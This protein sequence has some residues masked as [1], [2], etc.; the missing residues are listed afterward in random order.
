M[1]KIVIQQH[2][3]WRTLVWAIGLA[4]GVAVLCAG[5]F[6]QRQIELQSDITKMRSD[7]VRQKALVKR[8]DAELERLSQAVAGHERSRQ[9]ERQAYAEV[10]RHLGEVQSRILGLEEE[11]AFYR[12]IVAS[13]DQ[14]G[15][16]VRKLFLFP[17]AAANKFRYQVVLTR[18]MKDD[19]VMSG[20]LSFSV[21]GE[22]DGEARSIPAGDLLGDSELEFSFKH[23]HRLEGQFDLP[24]EFVPR[25]VHVRVK[26]G[27]GKRAGT[28]RAFDWVV[29]TG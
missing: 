20:S 6:I 12:S 7:L 11:V 1:N 15:V 21:S 13:S 22:S 14:D 26:A 18:H 10:D 29:T 28:E 2:K 5:Y 9:V 23:F 16:R 3:P 24:P 17:G 27:R 25:R 19:K 4:A 8:R